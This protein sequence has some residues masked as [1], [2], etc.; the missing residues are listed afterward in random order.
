V[1]AALMGLAVSA[2]QEGNCKALVLSGGGANGA[3]EV[4][5]LWGLLHYGNPDDFAYDWI[6]GISA[7]SIN[8][9]ALSGWAK[10]TEKEATEWLSYTWANL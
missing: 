1:I 9:A 2:Q 4:G 5:V 10:G 7:G 6:S 8:T 3:W